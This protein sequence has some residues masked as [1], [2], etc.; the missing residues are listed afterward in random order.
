MRIINNRCCR[1]T[2]ERERLTAAAEMGC[3]S[4]GYRFHFGDSPGR[5]TLSF[6]LSPQTTQCVKTSPRAHL[7]LAA[8]KMRPFGEMA[9]HSAPVEMAEGAITEIDSL[10]EWVPACVEDTAVDHHSTT[11]WRWG[12]WQRIHRRN[13]PSHRPSLDAT[14]RP[15]LF[16]SKLCDNGKVYLT[17]EEQRRTKSS[18]HRRAY[19]RDAPRKFTSLMTRQES[20]WCCRPVVTSNCT[21]KH[22]GK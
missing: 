1:Q 13:G 12:I 14:W 5:V 18:I 10:V 4:L 20:N 3:L 9:Y 6:S 19:R 17:E 2:D 11:V 7:Q 8:V 22:T 16:T 21:L 15:K